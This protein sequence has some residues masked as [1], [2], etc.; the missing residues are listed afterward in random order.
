[1]IVI[2]T[3]RELEKMQRACTLSA[4]ALKLAGQ[5]VEPGVSTLEI[6][7]IVRKYIEGQGA[8]PSFL[9]YGGFPGSACVSVNNVVIHGIPSKKIILKQGDIVSIDVGAYFAGYHGDNAYTF[10]CGDISKEAENLLSA[11][12]ESLLQGIKNAVAGNRIGD[13]ASAVQKYVED[14]NYSVVRDFVGHGVGANL[15]EEPSV[16]NFGTPHRGVRLIPG[17]TIAIEPM[18]NMGDYKVKVLDDEWTTVTVDGSLSAHFEH[19]IAI[20]PDGPK[21]MTV[22]DI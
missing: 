15:H 2:K 1:M 8:K 19:T 16:P 7:T 12:K 10:P 14:R 18:I 9:G 21:I 11:T 22:A 4:N 20:T 6:D 17:M 13:I 3:A 5:A